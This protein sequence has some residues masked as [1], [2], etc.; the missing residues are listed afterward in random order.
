MPE[1]SVIVPDK[2]I[3]AVKNL[4]GADIARAVFVSLVA[5]GQEDPYQV[6]L[7]AAGAK[8]LGCTMNG[9]KNGQIGDV[10]VEGR[11]RVLAGAGG[12]AAG[13]E[14]AATTAGA[15]VAAVAGNVIAGV[16]VRAAAA[17]QIGE[18]ELGTA[19][20]GRVVPA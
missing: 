15:A 3:R 2:G 12:I 19:I 5:A 14:V 7:P 17:G 10:Q 8:I 6:A 13:Q 1:T 9:I 11:T 18:V 20:A 4:S 16:C